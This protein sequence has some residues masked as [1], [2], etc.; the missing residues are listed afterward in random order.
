M[1]AY[2]EL[3]EL[4]SDKAWSLEKIELVTFFRQADD[5]SAAIG[6]RQAGVF[7]VFAAFCG[8]GD[9]NVP[10][11]SNSSAK[12]KPTSKKPVKPALKTTTSKEDNNRGTGP[13]TEIKMSVKL[14]IN[15]PSD[16]TKE[17]YDNIFRSI[18]ENLLND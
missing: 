16:G 13:N 3:F 10:K 6:T 11:S 8:H 15:I 4:H 2:A 18:K 17:T 9:L 5:T 14:E 12:A 7:Q 1:N